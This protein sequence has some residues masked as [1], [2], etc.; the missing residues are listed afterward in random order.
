MHRRWNHPLRL[1]G[2]EQ[3]RA[4]QGLKRRSAIAP[5]LLGKSKDAIMAE[6]TGD[7]WDGDF[8]RWRIRILLRKRAIPRPTKQGRAKTGQGTGANHGDTRQ[9]RP[10]LAGNCPRRPEVEAAN[11][12][13]MSSYV[14]YANGGEPE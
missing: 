12:F 6:K 3:D 14:S 13:P 4:S 1:R 2:M 9:M 7:W 5:C 8:W 10:F 11:C